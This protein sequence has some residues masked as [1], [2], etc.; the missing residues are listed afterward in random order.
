MLAPS[1]FTLS[2]CCLLPAAPDI[3]LHTSRFWLH[4]LVF[5][6][7]ACCLLLRTSASRFTLPTPQ[8]IFSQMIAAIFPGQGSQN[9]G[10][11]K[12]IYDSSA[13]ARAIFD[14]VSKITHVEVAKLCFESD[15]DTLRQTQNAQLA[16]FTCAVAAFDALEE[17]QGKAL[18]VL[19]MAGH[20]VGEYAALANS[21]IIE[22]GDGALFVQKRGELMAHSGSARPGT[23]AAVLGL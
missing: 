5:P 7:A 12:E 8:G 14:E 22:V 10:M 20:S 11:G 1:R 4:A 15:E 6:P 2:S 19:A 16:L 13:A 18:H 17:D 23:M 21:G 3:P 9:P